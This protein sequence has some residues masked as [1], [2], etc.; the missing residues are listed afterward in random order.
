MHDD[1]KKF[2]DRQDNDYSKGIMILFVDI[3]G[4]IESFVVLGKILFLLVSI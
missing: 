1:K 2:L 4:W 3:D